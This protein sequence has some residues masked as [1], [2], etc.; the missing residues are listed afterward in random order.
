MTDRRYQEPGMRE[1]GAKED[2]KCA[3]RASGVI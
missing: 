2:S 3:L 1:A